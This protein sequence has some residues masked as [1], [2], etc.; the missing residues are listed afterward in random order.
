MI[1]RQIVSCTDPE[2]FVRGD[3]TLTSF[4]FLFFFSW[5]QIPL[6]EGHHRPASETPFRWRAEDGP[7]LNAGFV[8]LRF[9]GDPDQY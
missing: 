7:T 1:W 2:S 3:P 8:D 5:I 4:F 6:C 9:S